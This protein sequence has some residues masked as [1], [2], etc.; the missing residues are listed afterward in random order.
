MQN[1]LIR[2]GWAWWQLAALIAGFA[3][4]FSVVQAAVPGLPDVALSSAAPGAVVINE[5]AWAGSAASANDEW[6]E[7]YNPGAAVVDLSGWKIRD[8][9]ADAYTFAAGASIAAGGYFLIEDSENSVSNITADAIYNMSLANA[10]DTIQIVD[11]TGTVID[12]VNGTSGA[13]YAGLSTT[14]ASMERIAMGDQ[15]SSFATSTGGSGAMNASGLAIVGTPRVVNSAGGGGTPPVASSE[16]KMNWSA[17]SANVGDTVQLKVSAN[18]ITDLF[19]Y[20]LVLTYD[21]TKLQYLDATAGTFLSAGGAVGTSF[22]KG[23]EAGQAGRLQLAEARTIDPKVG[24]SGSGELVVAS[25]K[26]LA[27]PTAEVNFATESF[28]SSPTADL[29][30]TMTVAALSVNSGVVDPVTGL[31]AAHGTGRYQ[32]KLSWNAAPANPDHYRV[33]RLDAH[34]QWKVLGGVTGL[35]FTDQDGVIGGGKIVPNHL[36]EYRVSAVKADVAS[37]PVTISAKDTRGLTG[38]NNRTDLI[39]GRDL[40]N[41]AKH[42]AETDLS[43]TFDELIDTTY[44]GHVDGSDLIDIGAGFAQKYL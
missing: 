20:G 35:E 18:S 42:F 33:E 1:N 10:G 13:W 4:P 40:D 8:D 17:A 32:I 27:G 5:I 41:L 37:V 3:A 12:T 22:Q 34:G 36:Y 9:G 16:V 14:F 38:D 6:I 43:L 31:T 26:V 19:S 21:S 7:L 44:D 23:L 24:V 28:L 11:D 2:T 39:D 25:F 15:A 29:Y 30:P